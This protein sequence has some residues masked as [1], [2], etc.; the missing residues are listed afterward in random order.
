MTTKLCKGI[1]SKDVQQKLYKS[2][3][4]SVLYLIVRHLDISFSVGACVW[5]QANPKESHLTSMK[6]IIHYFDGTLDYGL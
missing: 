6:R 1:S 5:Y 3:I 4:R 2:M